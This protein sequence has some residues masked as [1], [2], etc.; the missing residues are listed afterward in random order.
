MG[1]IA[2][3][4]TGS[5]G[6]L[7]ITDDGTTIQ[8]VIVSTNGS[9]FVSGLAWSVYLGGGS[10]SGS[11]NISGPGT[12]VVWSGTSG[13]TVSMTFNMGASG[14]SGLGGPTSVGATINR[15]TVPSPPTS[16][17]ISNITSSSFQV[18]FG[19]SANNGG[20]AV[21]GFIVR[22]GATNPPQSGAYTDLV[23]ASGTNV[24]TG[25]PPSTQYYV[26]VYAH[27]AVGYSAPTAAIA[28]KTLGLAH[29][30][31]AGVWG[32]ATPYVRVAGI[33]VPA[34]PY[35]RKAGVW[36]PVT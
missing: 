15:A 33:W 8:A 26:V 22:R 4:G 2:A 32:N 10:A 12:Y 19:N 24:I 29:I 30:R 25:L 16:F 34:T 3:V 14:T 21:D 27:N 17:S 13:S 35:V 5:G 1:V 7:E 11:V 20:A 18:N 31:S 28:V 6:T 9:T 36:S 23:T